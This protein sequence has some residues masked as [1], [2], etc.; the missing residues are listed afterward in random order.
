[1]KRYSEWSITLT[2]LFEADFW[3][4]YFVDAVIILLL[5]VVISLLIYVTHQDKDMCWE[6]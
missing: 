3:L 2:Y 1:M 4:N 6:D 5:D